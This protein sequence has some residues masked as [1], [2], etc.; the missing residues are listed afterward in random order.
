[1]FRWREREPGVGR[2]FG[3]DWAITDRLGGASL[4]PYAALNLGAGVQDDPQHVRT[5]RT[6]VAHAMGLQPADLRFV[7]QVHGSTVVRVDG[8][9]QGE[10]PEGDALISDSPD[11]G[12]VVLVADCTPVLLVDRSEG[13]IAAAHAGRK[14]MESGVVLEV[15]REMRQ[16]GAERIE[17]VVGPS[18]C[19]RCYEVP[20]DMRTH[21]ASVAPASYAVS[22]TG[23]PAIDVAAGVVEQLQGEG[24]T[25][26]WLPGCS[27]EEPS[28]FSH[29]RDGRTGR[30]AGV[31]RLL[32]QEGAA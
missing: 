7:R 21:A 19:A 14:G 2:A 32:P 16:L 15:V 23:T 18:I 12:L 11:V 6:L 17:A 13:V 27:R 31:V 1:M 4:D 30:F 3:V 9:P 8:R 10:V 22:W 20:E 25:P 28:L 5:N 26:T 29:R 24:I